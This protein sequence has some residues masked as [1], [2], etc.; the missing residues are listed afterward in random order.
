MSLGCFTM[1]LSN[2]ITVHIQALDQT[3][4]PNNRS[5]RTGHYAA[6]QSLAALLMPTDHLRQ[7][8][9]QAGLAFN[10]ELELSKVLSSI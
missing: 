1:Q 2:N 7:R 6:F 5:S 8:F 9:Q 4:P 3:S 10:D